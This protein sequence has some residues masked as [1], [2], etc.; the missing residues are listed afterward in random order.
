ML[1]RSH[2]SFFE[3]SKHNPRDVDVMVDN[4]GHAP[5]EKRLREKGAGSSSISSAVGED[6]IFLRRESRVK[7][8]VY[9]NL[10]IVRWSET[11]SPTCPGWIEEDLQVI[12]ATGADVPMCNHEH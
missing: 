5:L 11:K 7:Q 10:M 12:L 6:D 2:V 1:R 4:C 3:I 9:V 8:Y